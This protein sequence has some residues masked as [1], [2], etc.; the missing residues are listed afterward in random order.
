MLAPLVL[1]Q[2]CAYLDRWSRLISVSLV[3]G[4]V[5]KNMSQSIDSARHVCMQVRNI[6]AEK[7]RVVVG[8]LGGVEARIAAAAF[9]VG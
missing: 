7:R 5:L 9:H 1:L 8:G 2:P 3:H 4:R 6:K